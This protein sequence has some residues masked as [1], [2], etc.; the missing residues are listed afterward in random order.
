M[1]N[2]ESNYST[3][4][5]SMLNWSRQDPERRLGA[6]GKGALSV[7]VVVS[8]LLAIVATLLAYVAFYFL[9]DYYFGQMMLDRGPT[10]HA[11]VL[12][13]FWAL[14]ILIFKRYKLRLQRLPLQYPL[15]SD[16]SGFVLTSNTVDE[17]TNRIYE[18]AV[19][20]ERF[21]VFNRILIALSSLKNLGRV[22]DIDEILR[23]VGDK[24]ES[25]ME[26]SFAQLNGFLW[27]IPVLGFIGTVLGL[28]QSLS[29]FG[30]LLDESSDVGGIVSSLKQITGGLST[31]FETTLVALVIALALQLMMTAQ[32]QNEEEFLDEVSDYCLRQITS[33]IKILPFE[34]DREA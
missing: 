9:S 26:T 34:E 2:P 3:S 11:C 33:R 29:N 17:V 31:A 1:S 22:S 6:R 10:Q 30:S 32:K 15:T 28:S 13:G 16:R 7:G 18:V 25:A 5:K 19:D 20:P 27:A 4:R 23:S 21:V 8:G 24:D 12:F 14:F